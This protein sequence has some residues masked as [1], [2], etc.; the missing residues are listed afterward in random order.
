M[1]SRCWA[2]LKQLQRI[3]PA[4]LRQYIEEGRATGG[5]LGA[6]IDD[7]PIVPSAKPWE[8]P[9]F[10]QEL[11]EIRK[12]GAPK[13]VPVVQA[14]RLFVE[15]K[16]LSSQ[17]LNRIKR[18]AVFSNPEYHRKQ[19]LRFSTALTPRFICCVDDSPEYLAI[20]RGCQSALVDLFKTVGT[21]PA[22]DDKRV[23][24]SEA[25]FS[26]NGT[27]TTE[28]KSAVDDLF[29][30]ELGIL[31]APPGTGKTVGSMADSCPKKE[32]ACSCASQTA[33]GSVGGKTQPFPG[34][35]TQNHR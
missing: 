27:L 25:S 23:D 17:L 1:S 15:K 32:Y 21:E 3:E 16:G 14:Q 31:S 22:F 12:A 20:P 8:R 34:Y 11:A 35:S 33:Y 26:F 7:V 13:C 28:Q 30:H 2:F 10:A 19:R 9:V 6:T 24:G 18:L 29:C 4:A 5:I